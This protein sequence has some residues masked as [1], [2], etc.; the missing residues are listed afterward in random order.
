MFV[1]HD[2]DKDGTVSA[3]D[4]VKEDQRN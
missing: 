2:T 4:P 1:T 3:A